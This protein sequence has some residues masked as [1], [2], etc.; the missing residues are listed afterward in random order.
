MDLIINTN[1]AI[2]NFFLIRELFSRREPTS[3]MAKFAMFFNDNFRDASLIQN[4]INKLD[5]ERRNALFTLLLDRNIN[6]AD[7]SDPEIKSIISSLADMQLEINSDESTS[8]AAS[9]LAG[10]YKKLESNLASWISKI[11]GFDLPNHLDVLL[12]VGPFFGQGRYI[13]AN[14]PAVSLAF[15]EYKE[16][17]ISVLTHELLHYLIE[18]SGIKTDLAAVGQSFEEA[19]LDYFCP[20][21]IMDEKLG[22]ISKLDLDAHQRIQSALRPAS[23][24]SSEKLLPAIKEYYKQ[25]GDTTIWDFLKRRQIY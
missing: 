8:D 7:D 21:G 16:S 15:E 13:T 19:L 4:K 22:L 20:N 3:D 6:R 9:M 17:K 1:R 11:F 5:S 14:P 2:R 24:S 23:K 25:C 12:Y 18:K 10:Q